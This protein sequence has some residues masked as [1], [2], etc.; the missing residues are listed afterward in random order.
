MELVQKTTTVTVTW[1]GRGST[2][3]QTAVVT[4]IPPVKPACVTNAKTIHKEKTVKNVHQP[5][6][7]MPLWRVKAVEP[8]SAMTT[9]I[10]PEGFAIERP[11][12]VSASIT[13]LGATVPNVSWDT[14]EALR[15]E[16]LVSRNAAV[17]PS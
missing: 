3:P 4:I 15:T 5:A 12:T 17:E 7:E 10:L 14:T 8:V 13:R 6:T 1:A 11:E 2:A 16:D 9:V